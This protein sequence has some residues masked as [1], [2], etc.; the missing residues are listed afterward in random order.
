MDALAQTVTCRML[1]HQYRIGLYIWG[2]RISEKLEREAASA[3]TETSSSKRTNFD[4]Q[5]YCL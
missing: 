2:K 5:A 1:D 3:C 4:F